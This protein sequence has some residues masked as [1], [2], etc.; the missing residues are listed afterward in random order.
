MGGASA[1]WPPV[2]I[3]SMWSSD[4]YSGLQHRLPRRLPPDQSASGALLQ[5]V[6]RENHAK[7]EA[8][9]AQWRGLKGLPKAQ[10]GAER[11]AVA[12]AGSWAGARGARG[13]HQWQQRVERRCAVGSQTVRAVSTCIGRHSSLRVR[14]R[15][16]S[17][18]AGHMQRRPSRPP[19]SGRAHAQLPAELFGA[20]IKRV[21]WWLVMC[22]LW[23]RLV[24][25]QWPWLQ[26]AS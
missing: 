13:V 4:T 5:A 14:G 1:S 10:L 11:S 23:R 16:D 12:R 17:R 20:S 18:Q 2:P 6:A 24:G 3:L 22:Q 21:A 19:A 25:R 15:V 8:R 9:L 26:P 7:G